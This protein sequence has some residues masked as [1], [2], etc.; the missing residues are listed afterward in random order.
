VQIPKLHN[1]FAMPKAVGLPWLLEVVRGIGFYLPG[2]VCQARM[3]SSTRK[4]PQ[5]VYEK[6][7]AYL[8]HQGTHGPHM[9][10][11]IAASL[12]ISAA[13]RLSSAI[14]FSTASRW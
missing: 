12:F 14:F 2:L 8:Y 4:K 9:F 3:G 13:M 1:T 10:Q 5:A 7:P 6:S 11:F